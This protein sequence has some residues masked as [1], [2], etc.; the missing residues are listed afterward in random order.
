[1]GLSRS[2]LGEGEHEVVHLRTHSKALALPVLFL[3]VIIAAVAW[4]VTVLPKDWA[5]VSIWVVAGIAVI[6]AWF[7][8]VL[9]FLRWLTTTYTVTNRRIITRSGIITRIGHDLPISR[10]NDVSYTRDLIDRVLGCGTLV[11]TTASE[12]PVTLDDVPRV[13]RVHLQVTDLLFA[14][15]HRAQGEVA[16]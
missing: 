6:V 1:M 15:G 4:L 2:P 5:P 7:L 16:D 14:D 11:L 9:P 10:I 12:D 8:T 3:F 13:E